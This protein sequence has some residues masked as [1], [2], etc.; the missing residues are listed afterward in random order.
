MWCNFHIF[1][2][3]SFVV[4]IEVVMQTYVYKAH[5]VISSIN[6]QHSFVCLP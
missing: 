3:S 6:L 4:G 2:M 1:C 5:M